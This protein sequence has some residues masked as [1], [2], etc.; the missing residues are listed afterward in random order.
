MMEKEKRKANLKG[1]IDL[2]ILILILA[3][4]S[5]YCLHS[6]PPLWRDWD[7]FT[8]IH[9]RINE[10]T[11]LHW[12]PLYCFGSRIPLFLDAVLHGTVFGTGFSFD[13]PTITEGGVF[14]LLVVQHLLLVAASLLACLTLSRRFSSRLVVAICFALNPAL[15]AFANCVGS[16]AISNV[17]ILAVACVGFRMFEEQ[18]KNRVTGL[19]L[20]LLLSL[21]I[22]TRHINAV[23]IAVFPG[24]MLIA[25]LV[26]ATIMRRSDSNKIPDRVKE[27]LRTFLFVSMIGVSAV[28]IANLSIFLICRLSKVPYRSRIGYTF[29]WRLDYLLNLDPEER[30]RVLQNVAA[31]IHDAPTTE[32][33]QKAQ[34]SLDRGKTW[35]QFL[36]CTT[37]YERLRSTEAAGKKRARLDGDKRLNKIALTF[38]TTGG[39]KFYGSVCRD[40]FTSMTFAPSDVC[41]EPFMTT[42]W[43]LERIDQ[44]MYKSVRQL[45]EFQAQAGTFL[46]LWEKTLYFH[47]W[48]WV[49]L[50]LLTLIVITGAVVSRWT[51]RNEESYLLSVAYPIALVGVGIVISIANCCLTFLAARFTLPLYTLGLFGFC[52]VLIQFMELR[53]QPS[54]GCDLARKN[55]A[56]FTR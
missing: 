33:L 16:E 14:I 17:L 22:L 53:L 20:F 2:A 43:L 13:E 15:Y 12:P 39:A 46:K 54:A 49:P 24:T 36:L 31:K 48:A 38:L 9:G 55:H 11:I 50:W 44:Q 18:A 34:M 30:D 25:F 23:L 29:Q 35:D 41:R 47:L 52:T 7:G 32:A 8:Q 42:D 56:S 3:A 45:R 27:R 40:F 6:I 5:A 28:I 21:A 37:L 1:C 10:F 4:P 26:E 51:S 19:I